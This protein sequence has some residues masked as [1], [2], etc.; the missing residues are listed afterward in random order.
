MTALGVVGILT[1]DA[2]PAVFG[3]AALI[4]CGGIV[5]ASS[6]SALVADATAGADR[7]RMFGDQVALGALASFTA[8]TLAGALA[9]PVGGLLGRSG[10][11]AVTIR[12]VIA[13][14]GVLALASAVPILFVRSAPVAA[15]RL[16]PPHRR[17]L[18]L[19]FVA[20][21]AAFG[22]GAGGFLPF[23]NLYFADRFG[24]PLAG[25]GLAVGALSVAGSAGALVNGRLIVGRL[26][27]L[28]AV[29]VPVFASLP[30]ALLAAAAGD[31]LL[32]WV[33]LAVRA[34]LMYGSTPN[35]TAL[36]LS[37]F[38]PA[39][40]AGAV[41]LFAIGWN[42]AAAAGASLSGILRAELGAAGYSANL[43]LLVCAYLVAA[44]LL[45]LLFRGHEPRGDA[46]AGVAADSRS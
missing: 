24:L 28:A 25:V 20:I 33:A 45:V 2:F 41:A 31:P 40:R 12:A 9:A 19:R 1:Q 34:A 11:D 37:S 29:V 16:D 17:S 14:G 18:L 4:G 3:A 23:L 13:V 8:I 15:G 42:A 46:P 27:P 35:F 6:G 36:E 38:T 10:T 21:E 26:P 44:G 22:F 30:F 5:V 39:E 32:A 7:P 43:A